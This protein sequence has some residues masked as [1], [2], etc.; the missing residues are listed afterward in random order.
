[1]EL[2]PTTKI[3]VPFGATVGAVIAISVGG[4]KVGEW[5]AEAMHRVDTA[6]IALEAKS[7]AQSERDRSQSELI[8]SNTEALT[9][10]ANTLND[11]N[12]NQVRI[13]ARLDEIARRLDKMD[14]G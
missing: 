14:D 10:I 9:K 3:I 13:T 1:M 6:A 4:Y 12:Q 5:K 11:V 8:R 7:E 2:S